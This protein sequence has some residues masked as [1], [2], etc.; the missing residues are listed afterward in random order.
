MVYSSTTLAISWRVV[1]LTADQVYQVYLLQCLRNGFSTITFWQPPNWALRA[2]TSDCDHR[3]LRGTSMSITLS[4]RTLPQ[5]VRSV[6]TSGNGELRRSRW[7][8]A[9]GKGC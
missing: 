5:F 6:A 4:V 1:E 3:Y 9:D 2:A 7:C 8:Q